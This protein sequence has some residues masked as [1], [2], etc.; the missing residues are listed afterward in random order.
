MASP[1]IS[2]LKALTEV[3]IGYRFGGG[4]AIVDRSR[5]PISENCRVLGIG[6]ALIVRVSTFTLSCF[7]FS[8]T[9]TPNFCS[10]STI[11][12]PKSLNFTDLLISLCVP[13]RISILPA[14]K[15]DIISFVSLAERARERYST[16]TGNSLSLSAKVW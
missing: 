13:I 6:V 9:A 3:K 12:N 4:V 7:S 10:S 8:L 2:S 5:A 1:T 14:S 16:L 15:S 11:S